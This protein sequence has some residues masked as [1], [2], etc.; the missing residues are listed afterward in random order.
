MKNFLILLFIVFSFYSC[1]NNPIEKIDVNKITDVCDLVDAVGI[2]IN[3]FEK[4]AEEYGVNDIDDFEKD[5]VS[6]DDWQK[7][8]MIEFKM[9]ELEEKAEYFEDVYG[10]D[11]MTALENCP[12]F[13]DIDMKMKYYDLG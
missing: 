6:F 11:L 8:K 13:K 12:N 2:V 10:G 1:N 5:N 4:L 3:D 7:L 9:E